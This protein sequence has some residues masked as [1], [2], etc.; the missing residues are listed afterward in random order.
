MAIVTGA[1][2]RL[3]D[4]DLGT[5]ERAGDRLWFRPDDTTRQALIRHERDIA[6]V[7]DSPE[8]DTVDQF[9]DTHNFLARPR[10]RYPA[11]KTLFA[12]LDWPCSQK[13]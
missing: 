8:V 3:D 2:V 1:R 10:K 12:V 6:E 11:P 13:A 7:L 9:R 4:G 5:V